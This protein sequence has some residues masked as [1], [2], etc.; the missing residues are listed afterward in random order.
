MS[1]PR[2]KDKDEIPSYKAKYWK[3]R[4][5]LDEKYGPSSLH[6]KLSKRDREEA[7]QAFKAGERLHKTYVRLSPEE[8][9]DVVFQAVKMALSQAT[10]ACNSG[11]P[12]FSRAR[13]GR[14]NV[15]RSLGHSE[16]FHS[17]FAHNIQFG[18]R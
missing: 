17:L 8:L 18:R 13:S 10:P 6:S 14:H 4:A 3:I 5:E 2:E 11:S 12:A 15:K 1:N 9:F 16:V 7:K